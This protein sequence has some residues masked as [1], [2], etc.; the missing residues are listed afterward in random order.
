MLFAG[1][2]YGLI[3]HY[4]IMPLLG[5]ELIHCLSSGLVFGILNYFLAIK[6]Y[7]S[8]HELKKANSTLTKNINT[9]KLTM[10]YNRRAFDNDIFKIPHNRTYSLIF[11]DIDNFRKFNNEFGHKAGDI[12]LQR[13]SQ[14]IKESIRCEDRAYRYG[15][16]EIVILLMDCNKDKACDIAEK[17]R[18]NISCIDNTPLPSITVSIGVANCPDDGTYISN[19]V[20]ASDSALLKAKK[21]GKNCT[22]AYKIANK[23][24]QQVN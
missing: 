18:K 6:I 19:I 24:K 21:S 8:L 10:L 12:V 13:V 23:T 3:F 17:I 4:L 1:L 22:I 11:L 16:E 5:S 20:V 14:T 15:G 7:R 2:C 9:D